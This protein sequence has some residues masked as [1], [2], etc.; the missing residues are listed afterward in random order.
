[1]GP[2]MTESEPRVLVVELRDG[3]DP[4]DF[5]V[6]A[7][8]VG[9]VLTPDDAGKGYAAVG[10]PARVVLAAVGARPL[11]TSSDYA[12]LAYAAY[13]AAT[14]YRNYQGLPMPNW[15]DLTERIRQAWVAAAEAVRAAVA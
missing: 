3:V 12:Q 13:G 11:A 7:H 15:D 10:A 14:S 5:A 8:L 1:M 6:V 9:E 4:E 2:S